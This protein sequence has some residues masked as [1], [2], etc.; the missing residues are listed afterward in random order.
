MKI[1]FL[2]LY[3][4]RPVLVSLGV[5]KLFLSVLK[6]PF[7]FMKVLFRSI[8]F[9]C[10]FRILIMNDFDRFMIVSDHLIFL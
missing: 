2:F 4:D 7:N 8:A 5:L 1:M 3:R 6:R 9:Y 10:V